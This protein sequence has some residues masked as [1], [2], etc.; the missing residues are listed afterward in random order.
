[1]SA[2]LRQ[3]TRVLAEYGAAAPSPENED[4]EEV[5]QVRQAFIGQCR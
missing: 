1:M 4:S 3:P 2:S 5:A